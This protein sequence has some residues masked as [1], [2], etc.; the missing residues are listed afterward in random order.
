[1]DILLFESNYKNSWVTSCDL[2]VMPEGHSLNK[3][4]AG[5]SQYLLVCWFQQEPGKQKVEQ[6]SLVGELRNRNKSTTEI[7]QRHCISCPFEDVGAIVSSCCVLQILKCIHKNG[8]RTRHWNYT[9][10][11]PKQM[12]DTRNNAAIQGGHGGHSAGMTDEPA[13]G[14]QTYL[15]MKPRPAGWSSRQVHY[16]IAQTWQL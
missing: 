14:P 2:V 15:N 6:K 3:R 8:L 4:I 1:M 12:T 5:C 7:L 13:G 11:G 10:H 9:A 16:N